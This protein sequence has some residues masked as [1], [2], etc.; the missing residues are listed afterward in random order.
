MSDVQSITQP[1]SAPAALTVNLE[2]F[3][4][5]DLRLNHTGGVHLT[6]AIRIGDVTCTAKSPAVMRFQGKAWNKPFDVIVEITGP[7]TANVTINPLQDT[8]AATYVVAGNK[9]LRFS[10]PDAPRITEVTTEVVERSGN[11]GSKLWITSK[12]IPAKGF[13]WFDK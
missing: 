8:R 7:G 3:V 10:M 9:S 11:Y 4:P 13:F 2:H 1:A 5:S 12:G 6:D